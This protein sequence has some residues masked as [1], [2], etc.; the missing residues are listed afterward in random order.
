MSSSNKLKHKP[1]TPT[2]RLRLEEEGQLHL[3]P[4]SMES[5]SAAAT[6]LIGCATAEGSGGTTR[7]DE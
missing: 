5:D 1:L 3:Q 4:A 7:N 6:L 2:L